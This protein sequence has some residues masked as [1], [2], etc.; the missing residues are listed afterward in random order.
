LGKSAFKIVVSTATSAAAFCGLTNPTGE[1]GVLTP[2]QEK[3]AALEGAIHNHGT[4]HIRLNGQS[5]NE[6]NNE[7]LLSVAASPSAML[8]MINRSNGISPTPSALSESG[9][10]IGVAITS[11]SVDYHSNQQGREPI[12][13]AAHPYALNATYVASPVHA[14]HPST[15]TTNS[16]ANAATSIT[17]HRQP[18]LLHPYSQSTHPYATASHSQQQHRPNNIRPPPP[19]LA[20][21]AEITP[22]H[23][24][25]FGPDAIRYSP[26][27]PTPV[28]VKSANGPPHTAPLHPYVEL[29]SKRTSEIGFGDAL[30]QTLRRGSIDSGLGTSEAEN[31]DGAN[32]WDVRPT[33]P[34]SA[35]DDVARIHRHPGRP[36][37]SR[38]SPAHM[39]SGGEVSMNNTTASSPPEHVNPPVFRRTQSELSTGNASLSAHVANSSGSSPGA[40]S[41]DSSPPL[42]PHIIN[43]SDDLERFRDLFYRADNHNS[44]AYEGSQR[45]HMGSR[46]ASGSII[47]DVGSQRSTH[48][49]L[50]TLA[51]QLSE[52][53]EELRQEY[54][55]VSDR[56]SSGQR[57][58]GRRFGAVHRPRLEGLSDDMNIVLS[59][60]TTSPDNTVSVDSPLRMP[61]DATFVN[62]STNIPEDVESSR[63][64]SILERSPL[65]DNE[66]I[67]A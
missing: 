8:A 19:H 34:D 39:S 20:L 29:D 18:V 28:V 17:S 47:L 37:G 5:Y 65:H 66:V 46:Q 59:Q 36:S 27:I 56:D 12:R 24:R 1:K 2:D 35:I 41:H 42:S 60:R 7:E 51:R 49:G 38:P 13:F 30:K 10:G 33:R 9:E 57:S 25:Q 31:L 44:A 40:I 32:D 63:A 21:Y 61:I 53:L 62:P 52:E 4:K 14:P 43:P 11:A 50:S 48:S 26:E 15:S 3:V 23:V 54:G 22:D 58:W 67:R 45:P 64:S 55:S 16:T 6:K